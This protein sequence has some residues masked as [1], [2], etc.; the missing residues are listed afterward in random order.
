MNSFPFIFLIRFE[1]LVLSCGACLQAGSTATNAVVRE[2]VNPDSSGSLFLSSCRR[3]VVSKYG[4]VQVVEVVVLYRSPNFGGHT[5]FV[6]VC[7]WAF[8]M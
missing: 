1:F 3:F 6:R 4:I 2:M 7:N 8:F 5:I